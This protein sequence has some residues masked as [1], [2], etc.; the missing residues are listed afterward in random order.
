MEEL[1]VG[2]LMDQYRTEMVAN[3]QELV[4]IPSVR[5][6]SQ[7][8]EPFGEGPSKALAFMLSLAESWGLKIQDID[9]YAGHVDY[10]EGQ[11]YV[12]ALVHLDVVPEGAGWTYFPTC[13]SFFFTGKN[14]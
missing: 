11:D 6:K 10:G 4:R 3:L 13:A 12:A 5:G 9:G 7:L 8:G 2:D 14:P 1:R